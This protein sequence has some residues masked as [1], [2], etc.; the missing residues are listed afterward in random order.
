MDNEPARLFT[1]TPAR[2][3]GAICC[4]IIS[5]ACAAWLSRHF[6]S[7]AAS[8][9]LIAIALSAWLGGLGPGLSAVALSLLAFD[10]SFVSPLHSLH[11]ARIELPRMLMFSF[12][13]TSIGGLGALQN[14][15]ARS[16]RDAHRRLA[17]TVAM[18]TSTNQ[19]LQA[20]NVQHLRVAEQLRL[21]KAFLAEGQKISQTGCWRWNIGLRTLVWSDEH[22]R[23]FGYPVAA[24]PPDMDAIG[25]RIHPQDR[26]DMR[27]MLERAI[28]TNS[29]FEHEYRIVLA[30]GSIRHVLGTGRPLSYEDGRISEYIGT[31]VDVT[32]RKRTEDLLRKSEKAFRTL[33]ENLPDS[34]VRYNLECERIYVNP[35]FERNFGISASQALNVRLEIAWASDNSVDEF[36]QIVRRVLKTGTPGEAFGA[37]SLPG[38][39]SKYYAVRITAERDGNGEIVS[40]LAISRDISEARKANMRVEESRRL[41]RQL[42]GRSEAAREEE[43]KHMA[44]ELHDGLAQALLALKLQ[45]NVLGLEFGANIPALKARADAIVSHVDCAIRVV[46][47]A[48]TSLRPVAL[49]LGVLSALEWLVDEFVADTG[50]RCRFWTDLSTIALREAD[51]TALFRIAQEALR[52]IVRHSGATHA[53]VLL[54]RENDGCMLEINDNGVGFD[55]TKTKPQSFGLVGIRERVLMFAGTFELFTSPGTGTTVRIRIPATVSSETS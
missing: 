19:A 30:D 49:D 53:N 14:R 23:I 46:R 15:T 10:Y 2:Y 31:T 7:A 4:V 40:A 16:L 41:I 54:K 45:V 20:E 9:F 33:A 35:A 37:W 32:A 18:L 27:K 12:T 1:T 28:E 38:G 43:R 5:Y 48:I 11:V 52:N 24:T 47:N 39:E 13:A 55:A 3:V 21:S 36:K 42:A 26:D 34:V 29:A 6:E 8:M 25:E 51:T 17:Q 44:R 50:I 22:Y